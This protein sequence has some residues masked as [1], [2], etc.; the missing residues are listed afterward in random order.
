M[1]AQTVQNIETGR[2][3]DVFISITV[4]VVV[5]TELLSIDLVCAPSN[6]AHTG[7]DIAAALRQLPKERGLDP[8][9]CVGITMDNAANMMKRGEALGED[10]ETSTSPAFMMLDALSIVM[11]TH[12]FCSRPFSFR[13]CVRTAAVLTPVC[14]TVEGGHTRSMDR[15]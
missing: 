3:N 15:S 5:G 6:V 8:K 2:K 11:P 14:T 7:V 13:R 4:H 1:V 9:L 10:G 12:S